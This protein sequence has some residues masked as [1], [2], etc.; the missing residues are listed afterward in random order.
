VVVA[1]I[2][3]PCVAGHVG[4]EPVATAE[5]A[6]DLARDIHGPNPSLAVVPYPAAISRE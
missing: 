3:D 2:E 6:L 4:F 1:G 5:A